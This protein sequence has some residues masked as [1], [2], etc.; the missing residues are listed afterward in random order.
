MIYYTTEQYNN[1]CED[2]GTDFEVF[3]F[4]GH[5]SNN[6]SKATHMIKISERASSILG[7]S[8][9]FESWVAMAK[10]LDMIT[11]NPYA[12]ES[13]YKNEDNAYRHVS[14]KF[15]DHNLDLSDELL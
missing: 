13:N 9:E 1:F 11:N 14:C 3:A 4:V 8:D 5:N 10:H 2:T 7:I 6:I 12:H 15:D